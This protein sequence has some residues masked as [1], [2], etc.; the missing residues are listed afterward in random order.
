VIPVAEALA[1]VLAGAKP[2]SAEVAGL[3]RAE[4]RVLAD[5]LVAR[6]SHP[7][8][9]VSAMDGYAVRARDVPGVPGSLTVIGEAAAGHGFEGEVGTGEAVRIFTGAPLPPGADAIVIQEDTSRDGA[10][11]TIMRAPEPG[12]WIRK[13]GQDF[14]QG[15]TLLAA[16]RR[17]TARDVGLA[18]GANV[19]WLRVRR[20]PRVAFVATGDE[21]ALPGEPLGAESLP[22]SNSFLIA[23]MIRAFGGEPVNLGVAAD[24]LS[25]LVRIFEQAAGA[26]L[27]VTMG[28]ASVGDHD[29][30]QGALGQGD[31]ALGFYRVAMR[32]GKP[33]IFGRLHGMPMLG[34]PG[35]PVSVGVTACVFL[36]PLLK[37]LSGEAGGGDEPPATALLGRDLPA[38]DGRQD[39]LRARLSRNEAGEQV[40][41]PFAKQDSAMLR[42]LADAHCLVVRPP[43]AP[44]ARA[45][46]RV[47]ILLLD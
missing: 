22:S 3:E 30:V 19:P 12:R 43:H 7:S 17:L 24:N 18:A 40:A 21:I 29:L 6:V 31:F 34:L 28:G 46:E 9:D 42:L 13:V 11:V 4:G 27:L 38:N 8:A 14:A 10:Q 36:R 25:A 44:A 15:E 47:E 23:G 1:I 5:D 45:G 33:L 41:T 26:D 35:N 16:G 20:R 37:A 2:V 32:P 39:Y